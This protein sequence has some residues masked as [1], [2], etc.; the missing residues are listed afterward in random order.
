M[1]IHQQDI[2]RPLGLARELG[3]DRL[4]A[5]LDFAL[6]RKGSVSVAGARKR[7]DGLR[8]IAEDIDWSYGSGEEV[9]GPAE[10]IVMAVN[11][12]TSAVS[13]LSGD[14]IDTLGA[15]CT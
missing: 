15:R 3:P 1:L 2:R 9:R 8:L 7:A 13:D 10:A 5:A 14:G 12:R 6:S 4:T 11:G